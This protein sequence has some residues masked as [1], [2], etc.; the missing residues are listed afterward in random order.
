MTG[1]FLSVGERPAS[2][3]RKTPSSPVILVRFG[4]KGVN[5]RTYPPRE[6][7]TRRN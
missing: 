6:G 4:A 5:R 3:F 1:A 7:N 2:A